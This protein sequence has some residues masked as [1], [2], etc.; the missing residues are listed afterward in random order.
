MIY[1]ELF[2]IEFILFSVIISFCDTVESEVN[3]LVALLL[4][5]AVAG[6]FLVE[7]GVL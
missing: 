4:A 3:L 6:I 7:K 1:F 5:L 2:C